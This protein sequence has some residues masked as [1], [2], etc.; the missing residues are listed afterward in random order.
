MAHE[1]DSRVLDDAPLATEA[2]WYFRLG[3]FLSKR[4]IRGG[5]RLLL[6]ARKRGLLDRLVVY[7]LVDD[8]Q[9]V[10]PLWRACNA[11]DQDD[12]RAHDAAFVRGL[13]GAIREL[14][15]RVTLIDADADIGTLA[16]H[17]VTRCKNI[18]AVAAF[19]PN[20]TA[21]A[22]LSQNLRGLPVRADA[23]HGVLGSFSGIGKRVGTDVVPDDGGT[24]V[25]ERVDD[26]GI[27]AGTSCA[28]RFGV[29]GRERPVLAGATRTIREAGALLLAF[30][31]DPRIARRTGRDPVEIMRELLE[32][33]SLRFEID[34]TPVRALIADR[35]LFEQVP[36]DRVYNVIA[37]TTERILGP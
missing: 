18:V 34:T 10:V 25:V 37:R 27:R 15:G 24:I 36:P 12:V 20:R 13:S 2:P 32:I 33:R 16:A 29:E 8:V 28:L 19:E 26:L 7:S 6:E 22:V 17:L 35:P 14:P 3:R 1:F 4:N 11:W 31:T 23:H 9:L 30:E 21:H 5:D